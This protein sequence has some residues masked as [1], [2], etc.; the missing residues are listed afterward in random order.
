[1]GNAIEIMPSDD[2]DAFRE[3]FATYM[4]TREYYNLSDD[5]QDYIRD[6]LIAVSTF[7]KEEE[8][9][10]EKQL[11]RTVFPRQPKM[12]DPE[13][14]SVPLMATA[15]SPI[16]AAQVA[17]EGTTMA[18]RRALVD[19]PRPEAGISRVRMGGGG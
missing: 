9:Y 16:T 13:K 12:D 4:Q 7:G 3:V 5:I 8:Q 18:A 19:E 11:E 1:M 6:V 14:S 17:N 10:Q 15:G 2:L